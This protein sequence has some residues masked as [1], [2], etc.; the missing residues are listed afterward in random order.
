MS[1]VVVG[2]NHKTAPIS[3]L[4]RLR[5]ATSS[6][7]R[8]SINSERTST[9]SKAPSSR[10]ATASRSTRSSRSSTPASQDLRNF[11]SEFCH[12]APEDFAD[13]LYTYHDDGAVRHLFRVAAG[14]DSMVVGE[15][16]ILGQ[17]R[18]AY[19]SRDRT[20]A[21][22][23]ASS[24]ARSVTRCASGSRPAPRPRSDATPCRCR[25]PPSI[26]RVGRSPSD[27]L[28]GKKVAIVGAGKMG[29]LAAQPL[30]AAG[31]TT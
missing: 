12:V 25:R 3:L 13:H 16:E 23:I 7:P 27:T 11:L 9:S 30:A 18:R 31:A 29:R 20:R 2:L 5:S 1:V 21:W 17:V 8:R 22:C 19:Q 28:E 26:S 24:A 4:E 14:I 15:S 10:P 6:C